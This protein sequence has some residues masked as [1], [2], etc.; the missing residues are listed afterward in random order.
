MT[1]PKAVHGVVVVKDTR[2]PQLSSSSNDEPRSVVSST[3]SSWVTVA[4]SPLLHGPMLVSVGVRLD[5]DSRHAHALP[6]DRHPREEMSPPR[7]PATD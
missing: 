3:L 2:S 5:S 7:R 1:S 4:P 6:E